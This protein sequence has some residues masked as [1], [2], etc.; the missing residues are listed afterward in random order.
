MRQTSVTGTR[1]LNSWKEIAAYLDRGIR[2]V[3]RWEHD[4]ELPVHRIGTGKRSP[5]FAT[6]SELKFWLATTEA[7]RVIEPRPRPVPVQKGRKPIEDSRR[8]LSNARSLAQMIAD[9]SV[10]QRKQAEA[11]Q[12]QIVQMRARMNGAR[13]R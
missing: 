12:A 9:T 2:T 7:A 10:R 13:S 11:L 4:L 5:V 6:V 1:V 8:L 3:Q